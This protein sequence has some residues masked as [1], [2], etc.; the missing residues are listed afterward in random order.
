VADKW[1]RVAETLAAQLVSHAFCDTHRISESAPDCPQCEDTQAY[2][3]YL[4]AGGRDFRPPAYEGPL[5]TL[6]EAMRQLR[7]REGQG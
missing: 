2:L 7:E 5:T 3:A 6:P 4:K 1:K